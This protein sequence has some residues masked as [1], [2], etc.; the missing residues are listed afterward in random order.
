MGGMQRKPSL[1]RKDERISEN[2]CPRRCNSSSRQ[3]MTNSHLM[4]SVW[5]PNWAGSD[6]CDDASMALRGQCSSS[7]SASVWGKS[8]NDQTRTG[9]PLLDFLCIKSQRSRNSC[10][11]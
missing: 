2:R 9:I 7:S 4:V 5:K 10:L 6:S 11:T 8:L 1:D 3:F